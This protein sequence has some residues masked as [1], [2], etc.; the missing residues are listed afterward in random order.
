[1]QPDVEPV[2]RVVWPFG[3]DSRIDVQWLSDRAFQ[4][5]EVRRDGAVGMRVIGNAALSPLGALSVR[6]EQEFDLDFRQARVFQR[7]W[8]SFERE[9]NAA[10]DDSR[11][12]F[13]LMTDGEHP[14]LFEPLTTAPMN[15]P[16]NVKEGMLPAW[17]AVEQMVR[18]RG[19]QIVKMQRGFFG[20]APTPFELWA[21]PPRRSLL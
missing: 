9:I 12:E 7:V 15:I 19:Y 21:M 16:G 10:E 20:D 11:Q 17:A 4:A 8:K 13:R 6:C 3:S 14:E 18:L 5:T 2:L 1:M